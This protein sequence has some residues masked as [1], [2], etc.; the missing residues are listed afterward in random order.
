MSESRQI[1]QAYG[2]QVP[3]RLP[4]GN[5]AHEL[6]QT[7]LQEM[8]NEPPDML[9]LL[10]KFFQNPN[11]EY[12]PTGGLN[13]VIR[14]ESATMAQKFHEFY[15]TFP[16]HERVELAQ[17]T[18]TVEGVVDQVTKIHLKSEEKRKSGFAGKT[19]ML[20][21]KFCG[22][23]N[24]HKS[25]LGI[26]PEGNDYIS[27]FTGVLH[28]VI[29]ASDNNQKLAKGIAESLST[30]GECCEDMQGDIQLFPTETM[31]RLV[32]EF[33][34]Q[35]FLFLSDV[36]EWI[37][38][39]SHKRMLKSFNDDLVLDF[40]RDLENIKSKAT[41]I[42]H[43]AEQSHRGE[44]QYVR[45]KVDN[46]ENQGFEDRRLGTTGLARQQAE[47]QY[48]EERLQFQETRIEMHRQESLTYQR[49]LGQVLKLLLQENVRSDPDQSLLSN[50]PNSLLRE[51]HQRVAIAHYSPRG[52]FPQTT[53][54]FDD[55]GL[56]S[57]CL[58]D[59]FSRDRIRPLLD[60][61]QPLPFEPEVISRLQEWSQ[62]TRSFLLWIGGPFVEGPDS[63]NPLTLLASKVI[64]LTDENHLSVISYFCHIRRTDGI[65]SR[66]TQSLVALLYAL[67][68]QLIELLPPRFDSDTDLSQG[69]FS[70]LSG[71]LDSW[72]EALNVFEDVLEL[73]PG[74]TVFCIIDGLHV[75][76]YRSIQRP[77][78][79][80]LARLRK[81]GHKLRVLFTTSGR[82]YCLGQEIQAH[83]N[84]TIENFRCGLAVDAIA[85]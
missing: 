18:P 17:F 74:P 10:R 73:V 54:L 36:M 22:T 58:E 33:Y 79:L 55:V 81:G 15:Q 26:L 8:R 21:H 60:Y 34:G 9:N 75:L 31:I 52:K 68:R 47:R 30:I 38:N 35:V 46:L 51:E 2:Q 50:I 32:S 72:E 85:L 24:S 41:R 7:L 20:F 6:G 80:L 28:V 53:E 40:E 57:A 62:G 1:L 25:L 29:Q 59:H 27:I 5:D 82:S 14:Q 83:E 67:I 43:R 37:M 19:K 4:P 70:R 49:R 12:S 64:E 23:I 77:L 45:Y 61:Y 11:S 84:L 44:G 63:S 69:R 48:L 76:D 56:R 3:P 78:T 39:K 71:T 66:E 13:E 42:R 65:A 16:K